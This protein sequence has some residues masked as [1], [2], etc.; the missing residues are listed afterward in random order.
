MNVR[1]ED[2]SVTEITLLMRG[3]RQ[4]MKQREVAY[5][6]GDAKQVEFSTYRAMSENLE[7]PSLLL[8]YEHY[9]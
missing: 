2:M 3:Q 8:L 9:L 4:T 6:D 1:V 7:K 5:E